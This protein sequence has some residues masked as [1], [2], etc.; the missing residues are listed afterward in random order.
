[1]TGL[2]HNQVL[3]KILHN[4]KHVNLLVVNNIESYMTTKQTL[5]H[6]Q[7]QNR[8][9]SET[10]NRYWLKKLPNKDLGLTIV[11]N[12]IIKFVEPFSQADKAGIMKGQKIISINDVDVRTKQN[13]E[14]LQMIKKNEKYFVLEM[15]QLYDTK[16]NNN[17]TS[18]KKLTEYKVNNLLDSNPI[19]VETSKQRTSKENRQQEQ[20]YRDHEPGPK[21][22]DEF[23]RNQRN[24]NDNIYDS[25]KHI[26]RRQ[27]SENHHGP[28]RAD[29]ASLK[30]QR[31]SEYQSPPSYSPRSPSVYESKK[32]STI[33]IQQQQPKK[34]SLT[35]DNIIKK[36]SLTYEPVAKKSIK[37]PVKVDNRNNS[38]NIYAETAEIDI[39]EPVEGILRRPS[40]HKKG[41]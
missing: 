22:F 27:S 25:N 30:Q 24:V 4:P 10:S 29:T 20:R 23:P 19:L 5:S 16:A 33:P 15:V 1:M 34:S 11:P 31:Q 9:N 13:R 21:L 36:Q 18:S 28:D 17:A 32:K 35:H 26:S 41:T 40:E 37:P 12:G 3:K 2:A 7:N 38:L 14:I 6:I 8:S 39:H